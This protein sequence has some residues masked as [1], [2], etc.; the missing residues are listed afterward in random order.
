MLEIL[1]PKTADRPNPPTSPLKATVVQLRDL[2]PALVIT[3]SNV[4]MDS[5]NACAARLRSAGVQVTSSHYGGGYSVL[6]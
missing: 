4:L 2:P 6:V 5:G 1:A 3:D